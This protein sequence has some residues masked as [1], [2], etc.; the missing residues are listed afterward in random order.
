M[1]VTQG[2]NLWDE[3]FGRGFVLA[4][5]LCVH[6]QLYKKFP[7]IQPTWLHST[8]LCVQMSPGFL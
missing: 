2:A 7:S 1:E 6:D 3:V 5:G 4:P 8:S